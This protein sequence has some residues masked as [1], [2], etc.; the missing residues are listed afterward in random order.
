VAALL[1][2]EA[3]TNTNTALVGS[4]AGSIGNLS[5]ASV[6]AA[7]IDISGSVNGGADAGGTIGS[8]G[9]TTERVSASNM[10]EGV[11]AHMGLS[12]LKAA[13]LARSRGCGRFGGSP[14]R[15][16]PWKYSHLV[17]LLA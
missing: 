15:A 14:S 16:F 3:C 11:L 8:D 10:V 12:P 13:E 17:V 5:I 7:G 2:V 9:K 6:G 4:F 1:L